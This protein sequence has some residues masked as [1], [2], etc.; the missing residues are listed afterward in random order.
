MNLIGA[1]KPNSR[2]EIQKFFFTRL[3][4]G[5]ELRANKINP[6]LFLYTEAVGFLAAT[7]TFLK[8]K[9]KTNC[10]QF[11]YNYTIKIFKK[12]NF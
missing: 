5:D 12:T 3:F 9:E 1:I 8:K 10:H 7:K 6:V 11:Y 4:S 2:K